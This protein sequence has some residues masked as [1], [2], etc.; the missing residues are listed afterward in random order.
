MNEIEAQLLGFREDERELFY[1]MW[2]TLASDGGSETQCCSLK[3][4]LSRLVE[5]P[6]ARLVA[7]VTQD[8]PVVDDTKRVLS[9]E[10]IIK[11]S[12]WCKSN[13]KRLREQSICM[14]A[15]AKLAGSETGIVGL[16]P[17]H[18]R[19]IFT[20]GLMKPYPVG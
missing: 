18:I 19:S 16:T 12:A 2:V 17:W 15:A 9:F 3:Y 10:E 13:T 14:T 11:L 7:R 8:I 4:A 20:R 5:D 1:V 6:T